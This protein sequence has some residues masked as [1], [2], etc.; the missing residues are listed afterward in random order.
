MG[1]NQSKSEKPSRPTGVTVAATVKDT[2]KAHQPPTSPLAPGEIEKRIVCTK[3]A[4]GVKTTFGGVS[5]RYAYL[6]QRGFYP[7]GKYPC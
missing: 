3:E 2:A 4:G 6:S 1:C 5:V 7:D